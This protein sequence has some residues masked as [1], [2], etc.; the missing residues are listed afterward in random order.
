VVAQNVLAVLALLGIIGP[1]AADNPSG[2]STDADRLKGA[3]QGT[4]ECTLPANAP[5]QIK[6]IKHVTASHYT[7]V[8]YDSERIQILATSGGTWTV[9]DGKYE[10]TCEFATDTHQHLR[11]KTFRYGVE[12]KEDRWALKIGPGGEIDVD[13]VWNRIQPTEGQKLN[14]EPRGRS[15]LGTWEG[16]VGEPAPKS[17][18]IVKHVSP[19]HWTWVIY[20]RENKMVFA[21]MGGTWMFNGDRYEETVD[22]ST[23]NV[24]DARGKSFAYDF[25]VEGDVW[26][27]RRGPQ[28][29]VRADETW[30][31]VK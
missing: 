9:K 28:F 26:S 4:W 17:A 29:D 22:Y 1:P 16:T 7:W 31:R 5:R 14:A 3:L 24:P 6:H 18:R 21:A 27:I 12:L 15:L 13:E 8:T 25:K 11:G 30:K 10:E 23:E 2:R 20:D 19:T